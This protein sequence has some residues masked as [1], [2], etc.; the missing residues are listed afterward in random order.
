MEEENKTQ[1]QETSEITSEGQ[2]EEETEEQNEE[3]ADE[4][5][6]DDSESSE[7]QEFISNNLRIFTFYQGEW[8]E[9]FVFLD[10]KYFINSF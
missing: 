9:G 6:S 1:E 3:N 8:W 4:T 2:T 5:S 10:N 7:Q